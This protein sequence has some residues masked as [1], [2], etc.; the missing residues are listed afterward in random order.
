MHPSRSSTASRYETRAL[1]YQS[2]DGTKVP[3]FVTLRK[4]AA[5]DGS[6]PT[7]LYGYGGFNVSDPSLVLARGCR[8][9]RSGWRLRR[10]EHP[11][12]RRVRQGVARGWQAGTQ[13]ERLRRLHRRGQ[14]P[15]PREIHDVVAPRDH[16]RLERRPA[17]RGDDDPAAGTVRRRAAAGR[18]ARHDAVPH[19]HGGPT[20]DGRLRLVG[21]RAGGADTCW[22]TRLCTT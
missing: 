1:F 21:R 14:L 11:R 16:G 12:R 3:I 6:H 15:R 19:V 22:P 17:G 13:A 2:R 7:V 4:G 18:G 20:L 8:L 9:A 10:R 5:L